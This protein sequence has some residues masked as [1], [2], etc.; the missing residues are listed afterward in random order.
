MSYMSRKIALCAILLLGLAVMPGCG[1]QFEVSVTW[2]NQTTVKGSAVVDGA[3]RTFE[4]T[5][6]PTGCIEWDM[7][8][9]KGK[10]CGVQPGKP[11][12][13]TCKDPLLMEWPDSWT[14]TGATWSAPSLA[15]GGSLFVTDGSTWVLPDSFGVVTTDPGY[16][17]HVLKL[18][19][20]GDIGPT[21]FLLELTFSV[22]LGA[23]S[24]CLK[25]I[26]VGTVEL[27]PGPSYIIPG[28]P[29][30][31]VNFTAFLPGDPRVICLSPPTPAE[32]RTWGQIKSIFR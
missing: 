25:A 20:P 23:G 22:P 32:P 11:F 10:V 17:A 16:S 8:G 30:A 14:L 19:Y 31:G 9:C 5:V 29:A 12:K 3:V 21:T 27:F 24:A 6:G 2:L 18:D 15:V 7:D 13:V 26:D 4:G 28:D 1:N